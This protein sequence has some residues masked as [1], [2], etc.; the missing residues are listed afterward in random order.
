MKDEKKVC[1]LRSLDKIQAQRVSRIL[2]AMNSARKSRNDV[3]AQESALINDCDDAIRAH[4]RI[5]KNSQFLIPDCLSNTQ[6]YI[7]DQRGKVEKLRSTLRSYD[8]KIAIMERKLRKAVSKKKGYE[9]LLLDAKKRL[10]YE[11]EKKV[12]LD[13]ISENVPSDRVPP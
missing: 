9:K 7:D 13:M 8:N 2:Q 3:R 11:R 6:A 4:T 5:L 12:F 10:D 1:Q